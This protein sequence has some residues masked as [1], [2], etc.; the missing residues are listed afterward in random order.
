VLDS[1]PTPWLRDPV[2]SL[3]HLG[4]A[5]LAVYVTLLFARLTAGDPVKRWSLL[6]FGVAMIV[7]YTA[8]GLYHAVPG[9]PRDEFVAFFRRL[10]V[11]A[12][13][14]LIAGSFTPIIAVLLTGRRRR[15]MLTMIWSLATIGIASRWMLIAVP[16]A[17]TVATFALAGLPGFLPY[18]RYVRAVGRQAFAWGVAGAVCYAIGGIFDVIDW[19]N[20]IPGLV[21]AHELTHLLDMA[22]TA[23]HVIFMLRFVVPYEPSAAAEPDGDALLEPALAGNA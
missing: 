12:I 20:P 8:S 23:C 7:L 21:N 15:V 22:G 18:R 4:T 6:T 1:L 17:V 16:H 11:C 13:F 19:P 3:T 2:S 9:D 5:V 10:D 14:L